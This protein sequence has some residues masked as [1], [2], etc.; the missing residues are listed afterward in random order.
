MRKTRTPD[1]LP[2]PFCG[3]AARWATS[4]EDDDW[5]IQCSN[6]NCGIM[7]FCCG[8]TGEETAANW[9]TRSESALQT[10]QQRIADLESANR[11]NSDSWRQQVA[12]LTEQLGAQSFPERFACWR[13]LGFPDGH[14]GNLVEAIAAAKTETLRTTDLAEAS[15]ALLDGLE[16]CH[17][18]K[19]QLL[20]DDGP[21]HCEDCSPDCDDHE[22]PMCQ[23][24]YDLARTLRRSL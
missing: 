16:T 12:S 8:A 20:I 19:R 7:L 3:G 5:E 10:A 24:I 17:I 13:A 9:N 18:C 14:E 15:T 21:A 2:C 22:E 6:Q 1:L 23:S 4:T 11:A